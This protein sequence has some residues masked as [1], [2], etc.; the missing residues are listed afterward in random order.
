M[1]S[2]TRTGHTFGNWYSAK[3]NGTVIT[4]DTTVTA[5]EDH[6]IY[7]SWSANSYTVTY[8]TNGGTACSPTTKSVTYGEEYGTLCSTT[9]N[10]FEFNGW[11]TGD[12]DGT[13]VEATTKVTATSNHTLYAHWTATSTCPAKKLVIVIDNSSST[14]SYSK[15]KK[16]AEK[17]AKD[18]K[19]GEVV[20]KKY[21]EG[22]ET[23]TKG[24][25][26][27]ADIYVYIGDF[28]FGVHS[29]TATKAR[30]AFKDAKDRGNIIYC[31]GVGKAAEGR[32]GC[33]TNME[34]LCDYYID[35]FKAC[36]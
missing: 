23:Y 8:D 24:L 6:T 15:A 20:V 11:W 34:E 7:A 21:K 16:K 27:D 30:K 4:K 35:D 17:I 25:Y 29:G 1:C 22:V 2:P 36:E 33:D 31:I 12:D 18:L 26:V 13:K 5:K 19:V 3:T 28:E 10:G 9:K 14:S 32:D